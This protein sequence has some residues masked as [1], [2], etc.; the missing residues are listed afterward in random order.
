MMIAMEIR[1]KKKLDEIIRILRKQGTRFFYEEFYDYNGRFYCL[2]Y[3]PKGR[4]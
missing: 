3:Y 2:Y 4:C 1:T